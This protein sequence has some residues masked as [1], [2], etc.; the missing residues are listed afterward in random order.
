MK[1]AYD[2]G[3]S[4][5][6]KL[7]ELLQS[8]LTGLSSNKNDEE[9]AGG[10]LGQLA[11]AKARLAA[12]GTEAE[13]AKVKIGL[14]EKELKEKE[15]RAKKA[16][17]DGEGLIKELAAKRTQL[18]KLRK[19]VESAGWDEQQ[20]RE[21]LESQAQHQSKMTEL[22][23]VSLSK[24]KVI[25][26]LL[27]KHARNATCLNPVLHQLISRTLILKRTLTVLKSRVLLPTW[28]ILT[29]KTLATLRLWKSALVE[30]FITW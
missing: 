16:E 18:E 29:K 25:Y 22:M 14:A 19:Q 15:P 13:Q 26:G 24:S 20:E 28:S 23:E 12:A 4:E 30:S 5:L 21:M 7:E 11:E 6:S 8:L 3:Q 1:D 17:K 10:Y 2:A 27:T 9:N